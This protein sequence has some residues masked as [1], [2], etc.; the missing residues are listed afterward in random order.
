MASHSPWYSGANRVT[1]IL[2]TLVDPDLPASRVQSASRISNPQ[3]ALALLQSGRSGDFN[4]LDSLA[5]R[6][7]TIS[8]AQ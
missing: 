6:A 8:S 5:R 1:E 3:R 7:T 2:S 4:P